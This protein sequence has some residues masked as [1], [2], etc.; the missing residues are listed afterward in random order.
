MIFRWLGQYYII[1]WLGQYYSLVRTVLYYAC[2][3]ACVV[4]FAVEIEIVIYV[5][6]CVCVWKDRCFSTAALT[7]LTVC[8]EKCCSKT[9]HSCCM[10][11]HIYHDI[12][13]RCRGFSSVSLSVNLIHIVCSTC[14]QT[15]VYDLLL[16]DIV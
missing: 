2:V 11:G 4:D 13:S 8:L 9:R 15:D 12:L 14:A 6:V 1:H 10:S 3:R 7:W 16:L 5:C